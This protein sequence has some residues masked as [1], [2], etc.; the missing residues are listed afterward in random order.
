MSLTSVSGGRSALMGACPTHRYAVEAVHRVSSGQQIT[1]TAPFGK[2]TAQVQSVSSR[3][4]VKELWALIMAA[5][6]FSHEG[7]EAEER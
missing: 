6:V 1:V 3:K 4:V 2:G 5:P 7:V